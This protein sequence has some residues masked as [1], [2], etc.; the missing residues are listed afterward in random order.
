MPKYTEFVANNSKNSDTSII[1]SIDEYEVIRL[2]DYNGFTQEMCAKQ[3]A[4]SRTSI[5]SIYN[6]ARKKISRFFIEG[7][8]LKI[9]GG[10]VSICSEFSCNKCTTN[11]TNIKLSNSGN[12]SN[13]KV[14]NNMKLAVTYENGQIFQHFG[15][16]QQFK[17]YNIE[18][19]KITSTEIIDTKGNGHGA[20]GNFLKNEQVEILICGGIGGGA[21][22]ALTSA[23]I[24]FYGGATGDADSNV[25]SFLKGS[26]SYNPNVMCSHHGEGHTCQ[27]NSHHHC[28]NNC[29]H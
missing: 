6:N 26:L 4:V 16:T 14:G 2:I 8:P 29:N 21:Q 28:G 7:L 27:S 19:G 3:M 20:L 18:D 12:K 13:I 10:N 5:Q 24:K 11:N 22:N 17:I 25:E 1:L 9:Y 23:G 15:H